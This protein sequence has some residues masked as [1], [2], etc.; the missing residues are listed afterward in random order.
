MQVLVSFNQGASYT[1]VSDQKLYYN[2]YALYAETAGKLGSVLAIADGGTGAT[3]AA[4][5]RVNLG[6]GNIDNTS[7]AAKPISTA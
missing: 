1:K 7:D 5:A 2:P 3:T 4:D 6:L